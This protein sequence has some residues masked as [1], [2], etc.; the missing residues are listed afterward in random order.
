MR[1]SL[2]FFRGENVELERL[3]RALIAIALEESL[4]QKKVYLVGAGQPQYRPLKYGDL[5]VMILEL[6]NKGQYVQSL[7][8]PE[9]KLYFYN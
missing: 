3:E 5:N 2:Q 1:D 4:Y 7:D 8:N 6:D 9:K